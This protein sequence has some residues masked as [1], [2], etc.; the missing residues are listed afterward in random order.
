[1]FRIWLDII[2]CTTILSTSGDLLEASRLVL[3]SDIDASA[4]NSLCCA[5]PSAMS[6]SIV[7]CLCDVFPNL[8]NAAILLRC[9]ST[10]S[11][12]IPLLVFLTNAVCG[13]CATAV[14]PRVTAHLENL[15]VREFKSGQGK[16]K[17][18]GTVGGK[19]KKRLM[20]LLT[21]GLFALYGLYFTFSFKSF[22]SRRWLCHSAT[23][24][25]IQR[26]PGLFLINMKLCGP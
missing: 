13:L 10:Q 9:L 2:Y 16:W 26:L 21:L 24:A 15:E 18:R 3:L 11:I 5:Q 8:D 1:M 17:S 23:T 22:C 6:L 7:L 25:T 12:S 4:T 20:K 14:L 19:W